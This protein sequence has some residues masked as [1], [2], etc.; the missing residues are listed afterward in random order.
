MTAYGECARCGQASGSDIYDGRQ[1]PF[2]GLHIKPG[3]YD[4]SA[5]EWRCYDCNWTPER[6]R[7][8][9]EPGPRLPGE[10]RQEWRRRTGGL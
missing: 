2:T 10:S 8:R 9:R 1:S 7:E 5:R 4:E 6:Q 3:Y